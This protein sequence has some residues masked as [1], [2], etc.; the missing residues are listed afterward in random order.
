M[1]DTSDPYD[2]KEAM[3]DQTEPEPIR[4]PMLERA[5]TAGIRHGFFTRA[6]GVSEGI[7]RGLNT[8]VGSNDDPGKVAENRR[9][10]AAWMRVTP[11]RLLSVHQIHSP[12][13]IVVREA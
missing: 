11:E 13:V 8:G 5:A 10:V 6:G 12:N 1:P 9:R 7:Y 4:S 2:E 3:L